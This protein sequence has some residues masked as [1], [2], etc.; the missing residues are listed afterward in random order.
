MQLCLPPFRAPCTPTGIPCSSSLHS[1]TPKIT[2][3]FPPL[4][5]PTHFLLCR[6]WQRSCTG[7]SFQGM[8]SF[9]WWKCHHALFLADQYLPKASVTTWLKFRALC[10]ASISC[11]VS[12]VCMKIGC[13][14]SGEN[15][16]ESKVS[17]LW[18]PSPCSPVPQITS[19]PLVRVF[20]DP[21]YNTKTFRN[22]H[23]PEPSL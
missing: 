16:A 13:Y 17:T 20:F 18:N 3:N 22:H 10:S 19:A 6:I 9:S 12:R 11:S 4:Q 14:F 8:A 2:G 7:I 21:M 5:H 23:L 15:E 1:L